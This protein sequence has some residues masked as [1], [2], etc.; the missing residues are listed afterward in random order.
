M[1]PSS[2]ESPGFRWTPY[3]VLA[4]VALWPTVGPAEAVLSLGAITGLAMLAL[5]RFRQGTMLLSREAW[6][7]I[8]ALFFCYWLPEAFSA[9]DAVDRK[10]GGGEQK[11]C[12][13]CHS[14]GRTGARTADFNTLTDTESGVRRMQLQR[15]EAPLTGVPPAGVASRPRSR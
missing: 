5:R 8:T 3:V 15:D 13:R 1:N 14:V 10:P 2:L 11:N 12:D 7:L 9:F 4:F 6:A